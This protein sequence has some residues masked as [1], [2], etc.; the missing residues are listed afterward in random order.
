[1]HHPYDGHITEYCSHQEECPSV[2]LKDYREQ[3]HVFKEEYKK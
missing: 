3:T 2:P 1:M